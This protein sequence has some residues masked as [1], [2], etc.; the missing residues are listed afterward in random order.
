MAQQRTVING[1]VLRG[2]DTRE[3][4]KILTILS[5]V[6]KLAV[7]AKGA[8]G[9]Q[10]RLAAAAQLLA[11]SELTV[12]GGRTWLY[13]SEA[14]TIELFAGVRQDIELLSLASYFAELTEAVTDE[15]ME[16][17][18]IL[19]LLLNALYAL[20]ELRKP[21]AQVKAA[22]ELKLM[23]L[24]GFEPLADCCAVCGRTSPQEPVLDVV[25]GVVHCRS[26][27]L[28]E[29]GRC[30]QLTNGALG[31]I[32]YILYGDEKRLYSFRLPDEDLLS[33]AGAAEQYTLAAL[34]RKFRTLDFYHSLRPFDRKDS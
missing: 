3:S 9:R 19:R 25:N 24:S 20:G 23:S 18:E 17:R 2:T 15:N 4:D 1:I 10:S 13:L 34:D 21:Q 12:T 27:V 33:L 22:F 28:P 11:Y 5:P 16:C 32:R 29:W 14:A 7:I 30:V 6:G 8:R 26:C 31:A